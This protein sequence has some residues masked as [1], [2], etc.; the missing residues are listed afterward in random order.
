MRDACAAR[1]DAL[2]FRFKRAHWSAVR[3]GNKAFEKADVDAMTAARFDILFLLHRQ[4]PKMPRSGGACMAQPALRA[5]LGLSGATI[6]KMLKRLTELGLVRR[7]RDLVDRRRNLV[8][9]TAEGL[10]RIR[11]ALQVIFGE[12][13]VVDRYHR[14]LEKALRI[15]RRGE[16]VGWIENFTGVIARLARRL[17]DT[18]EDP[19]HDERADH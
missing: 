7:T 3:V 16:R 5:A 9:L 4:A 1:M 15:R 10:G 14:Y 12:R 17:G 13:P 6:S 11:A 18:A 2:S 8:W 19:Y